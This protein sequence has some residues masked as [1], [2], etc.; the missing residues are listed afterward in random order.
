MTPKKERRLSLGNE[1]QFRQSFFAY[2][3]R[4][5][6]KYLAREGKTVSESCATPS[7]LKEEVAAATEPTSLVC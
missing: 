7:E 5:K 6:K 4:A 2:F 3:Q 1:A